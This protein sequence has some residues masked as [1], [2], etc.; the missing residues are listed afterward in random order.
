MKEYYIYV[1]L[2]EFDYLPYISIYIE[3]NNSVETFLISKN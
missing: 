3:F 2:Y 1:D